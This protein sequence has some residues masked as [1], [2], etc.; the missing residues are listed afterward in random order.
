MGQAE[1]DSSPQG[2]GDLLKNADKDHLLLR[3]ALA[4]SFEAFFGEVLNLVE[5]ALPP[6]DGKPNEAYKLLRSKILR[7]GND[8]KRSVENLLRD[9]QVLRTHE[10][11][12]TLTVHFN[13]NGKGGHHG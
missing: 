1:I 6:Q 4:Q 11:I 3:E 5:V 13:G 8:R 2:L 7:A 9:Y 12:R 10:T